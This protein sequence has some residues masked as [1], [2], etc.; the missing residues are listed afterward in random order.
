MLTGIG[1]GYVL[2]TLELKVNYLRPVRPG[3]VIVEGWLVHR[4]KSVAFLEG[5]VL[6]EEGE[7]CARA[8]ATALIRE[9]R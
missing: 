1:G 9:Y 5:R 8:T 2:P 6:N 3:R 4:G 7:E